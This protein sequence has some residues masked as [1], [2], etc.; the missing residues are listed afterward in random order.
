MSK[1]PTC[2]HRTKKPKTLDLFP[3]PRHQPLVDA[4]AEVYAAVMG[5]PYSFRPRDFA[6]VKRLLPLCPDNEGIAFRWRWALEKSRDPFHSP[7]VHQLSDLVLHWN[8]YPAAKAEERA[9]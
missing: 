1:C 7:K 3:N 8:A 2:G 6:D 5:A 4:L 9:Q